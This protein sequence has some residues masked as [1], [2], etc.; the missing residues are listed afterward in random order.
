[1][2]G[3]MTILVQYIMWF[4]YIMD[5]FANTAEAIAGKYFGAR[6]RIKF[7]KVIKIIFIWSLGVSLLF[8]IIFYIFG[9]DI[10][11]F[12]TNDNVIIKRV[13]LLP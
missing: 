3:A 13:I 7:Y 2:L 5:S 9:T 8:M 1:M 6:D 10:A 12:Y 11:M 4:S